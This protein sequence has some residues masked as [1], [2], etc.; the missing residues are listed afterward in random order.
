M[1]MNL[2]EKLSLLRSKMKE[3]GIDMFMTTTEDAYLAESAVDYWRGLRW[4]TG[5]SGTLAYAMVTQE[6]VSFW[7]DARYIIQAHRQVK[8]KGV[9]YYDVTQVGADY[10]LEWIKEVL[11]AMPKENLVFAVDERTITTAKGLLMKE[12]LESLQGKN[13]VFRTDLDLVDEIWEDRPEPDY[14]PIFEHE[15]KYAGRSRQEKLEDVRNELTKVGADH[16][17]VGTMEGVVWLT[18]MRGQDLINPL[19]MSHVLVTPKTA[20]LF[21]RISMIPEG[22]QEKLRADGYE[23]F[24]IEDAVCEIEKL[25]SNTVLYYDRFRVNYRLYSSVPPAVKKIQGF[26][27]VND[28]K[29]IKNPVELQNFIHTNTMECVALFR[30]F[31]YIKEHVAEGK[32]DEYNVAEILNEFR[33]SNPEYLWQHPYQAMA[34]YME[35]AAGPHYFATQ[36]AHETLKPSGVLLVDALAHYYGGSTDI[37]RTIYLGPCP[38]Y[39]EEIRHDY[40]LTLRALMDLVRQVFR[41]G[42]DG[43]YL[44]SVARRVMW[45]E[46]LHYG[47]GTGHGIGYCI[48][49]HEGP[50]FIA[51]PSY[52]KEWAFCFLPLKLNMVMALEPGVYKEGKYGI[53]IE[54]NVYIKEDIVNEFGEFYCFQVMSYLPFERELIDISMLSKDEIQWIDQYHKICYQNLSPYLNEAEKDALRKATEPLSV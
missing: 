53:R 11:S 8:I 26:D 6:R 54:D 35:N 49:P 29:S 16:T 33:R 39:E 48:V 1:Q 37:T 46:H 13:C 3:H 27:L 40:T 15:L 32:L 36:E 30:F 18:N 19:F 7:T 14:R 44:D 34:A 17:I 51:E 28:L 9:E 31:T 25:S 52:K 50:Q 12:N 24:E 2:D 38:E 21:A 47:Y 5:F 4:L 20:K 43:A 22:L 45:N 10:Y 41:K 42:T 23:L